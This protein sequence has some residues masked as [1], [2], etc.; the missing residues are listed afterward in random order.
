MDKHW[1]KFS[2][3]WTVQSVIEPLKGGVE[4][5][6]RVVPSTYRRQLDVTGLFTQ[7]QPYRRSKKD[8]RVPKEFLAGNSRSKWV[9]RFLVRTEFSGKILIWSLRKKLLNRY[10]RMSIL[11]NGKKFANWVRKSFQKKDTLRILFF[12]EKMFDL[13][14]V[15]N[16][17]NDRIWAV[18]S[19]E[20]NRKGGTKKQ[21]KYPQKAMA[22]LAVSSEGVSLLVA[23]EKGTL[24]H[25]RYITEVFPIAL[26]YGNS[27]FGNNWIFQQDN[28]K[29]H[30]PQETQKGCSEHFSRFLD[31]STW[32]A[33]SPD[34]NPMD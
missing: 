29:P 28:G 26:R 33:N 9:C 30:T 5:S 23:F 16:N 18:D 17:H 22:W 21:Q 10:S 2:K 15:Y 31:K 20:A 8:Q 4:W 1:R 27:K 14:G 12:D 34:L 7:R 13:D 25:H 11:F 6:G 3:I 32:P 24:D 19:E